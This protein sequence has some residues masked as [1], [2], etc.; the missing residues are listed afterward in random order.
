[1]LV[2]ARY[3]AKA[4]KASLPGSDAGAEGGT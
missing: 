2:Y 3:G 1:M 4:W